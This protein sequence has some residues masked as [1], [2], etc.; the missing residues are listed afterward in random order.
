MSGIVGLL[1]SDGAPANSALLDDLTASLRFRGPDGHEVWFDGPIG[2]GHTRVVANSRTEDERQPCTLD[3]RLWISADIRL[4]YRDDLIR[5]LPE[6]LAVE[7][8]PRPAMPNSSCLRTMPG[9][10]TAC[11]TCSEISHSFYG[12]SRAGGF[13]R[14]SIIFASSSCFTRCRPKELS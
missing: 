1:N 4:D 8:C 13:W 3:G 12:T 14:Q 5:R 9:V 11:S 10:K 7:I 6:K 2:L